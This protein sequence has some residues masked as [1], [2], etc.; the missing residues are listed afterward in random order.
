MDVYL[1]ELQTDYFVRSVAT[2]GLDAKPVDGCSAE[3][4]QRDSLFFSQPKII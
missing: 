1:I 4:E 3:S 2:M